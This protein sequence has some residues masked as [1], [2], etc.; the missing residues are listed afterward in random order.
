MRPAGNDDASLVDAV[1]IVHLAVL[2]LQSLM[3]DDQ[4]YLNSAKRVAQLAHL[5]EGLGLRLT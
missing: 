5:Q 1:L 4:R 2:V 3:D